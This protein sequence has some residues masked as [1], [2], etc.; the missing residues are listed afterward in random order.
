[1]TEILGHSPPIPFC[2]STRRVPP[3]FTL[4]A[5]PVARAAVSAALSQVGKPYGWGGK[6]PEAVACSGLTQ[7]VWAPAG[8]PPSSPAC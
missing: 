1:M 5:D 4:P 8:T 7:A 2:P 6:G 3:G